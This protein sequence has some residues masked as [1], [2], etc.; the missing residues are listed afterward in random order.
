MRIISW[1]RGR[2]ARWFTIDCESNDVL[3][4]WDWEKNRCIHCRDLGCRCCSGM[5]VLP[6]SYF[7][8]NYRTWLQ[9]T[10]ARSCLARILNAQK[11][12]LRKRWKL[13]A[14]PDWVPS[15]AR[16]KLK[17]AICHL[18]A[19]TFNTSSLAIRRFLLI[20]QRFL[21]WCML[22]QIFHKLMKDYF[23]IRFCRSCWWIIGI[24]GWW[25]LP[26]SALLIGNGAAEIA[27]FIPI[28]VIAEQLILG[29]E[30]TQDF[31]I[32]LH[33]GQSWTKIGIDIG[34]PAFML[35]IQP[36]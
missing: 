17:W 28:G 23:R 30:D 36:R 29:N 18:W 25:R 19:M 16:I 12:V 24:A 10:K 35:R 34:G 11:R 1:R 6:S 13:L 26:G 3:E 7:N 32:L 20:F 2:W 21:A 4:S 9:L 15:C 27:E 5:T 8:F 14:R 22:E 31:K 33:L